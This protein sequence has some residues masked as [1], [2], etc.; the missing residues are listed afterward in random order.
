[1][2]K[3]EA[4]SN[5]HLK[6]CYTKGSSARNAVAGCLAALDARLTMKQLSTDFTAHFH[7]LP[8]HSVLDKPKAYEV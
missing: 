1:M 6:Q 5:I 2:K 3:L 8:T 7:T 4:G